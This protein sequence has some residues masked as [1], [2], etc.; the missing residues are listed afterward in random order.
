MPIL[1]CLVRNS[2]LLLTEASGTER[3]CVLSDLVNK[4]RVGISKK[5]LSKEQQSL[6]LQRL[7][8][9]GDSVSSFEAQCWKPELQII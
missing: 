2:A 4:N 5:M 6:S 3:Y 7:W 9:V 8:Q 1:K